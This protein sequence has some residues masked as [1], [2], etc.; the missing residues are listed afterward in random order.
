ME[1]DNTLGLSVQLEVPDGEMNLL[2][3]QNTLLWQMTVCLNLI[4]VCLDIFKFLFY[5]KI[6]ILLKEM[7]PSEK[8]ARFKILSD[9]IVKDGGET[10][11]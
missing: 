6:L 8:P 9:P 3:K 5:L 4:S 7:Q 10:S 1:E 11:L 2:E